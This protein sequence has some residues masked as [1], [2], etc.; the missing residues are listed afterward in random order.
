MNNTLD[1][2][3]LGRGWAFPPQFDLQNRQ[4]KLV[5]HEQDIR[6]SLGILLATAPGERVMQPTYG[7]GLKTRVF[8][9]IND[10]TITLIR[11]IVKRAVLFFEPRI[12]LDNIQVD[13]GQ[14]YDGVL[15][16]QLDYT[17]RTTN[18]RNNMVYPFYFREGT[19][20]KH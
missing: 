19:D 14:Q 17:V 16:I 5:S 11:D 13:T 9:N 6:E 4:A 2:A 20:I 18:S 7:C 3:F 10:S 1:K 15:L 12:S 8:D